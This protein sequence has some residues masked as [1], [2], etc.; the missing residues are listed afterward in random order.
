MSQAVQEGQGRRSVL[1]KMLLGFARLYD[2][3][4]R[5]FAPGPKVS[6]LEIPW[7]ALPRVSARGRVISEHLRNERASRQEGEGA[8][9]VADEPR[10]FESLRMSRSQASVAYETVT[11]RNLSKSFGPATSMS[12]PL[13]A[14]SCL[15]GVV[16]RPCVL[17]TRGFI[18]ASPLCFGVS[19]S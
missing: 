9:P 3:G 14:A 10:D 15:S 12:H 13:S 1:A 7:S 11:P 16:P 6:W 4:G 8:V 18:F 2:R 19:S 5:A 17:V